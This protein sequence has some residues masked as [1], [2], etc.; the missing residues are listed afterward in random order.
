M[1]KL[2]CNRVS[3]SIVDAFSSETS[4]CW[5]RALTFC[6][7]LLKKSIPTVFSAS[8][9]LSLL[10]S[11]R[12]LG[13]RECNSPSASVSSQL[14]SRVDLAICTVACDGCPSRVIVSG[15]YRR[16][17]HARRS[18]NEISGYIAL[19][20]LSPLCSYFCAKFVRGSCLNLGTPGRAC[21]LGLLV[22]KSIFF[23]SKCAMKSV[24]L[25]GFILLSPLKLVLWQF[26]LA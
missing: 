20:F 15:C 5:R 7:A 9:R 12:S 18:G 24:L 2:P 11:L 1:L 14:I 4:F 16:R 3:D 25:R 23:R 6:K 19:L 8:N 22:A 21:F 13:S 10:T 26:G 17:S